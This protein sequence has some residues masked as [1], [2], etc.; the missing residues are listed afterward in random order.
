VWCGECYILKPIIE[1]HIRTLGDEPGQNEKDPRDA[2]RIEKAWGR[3]KPKKGDC[4]NARNS[5]YLKVPF[6]CDLCI[7]PKLKKTDPLPRD[8]QDDPLLACVRCMTLD[9]FWSRAWDTVHGNREKLADK[10]ALSQLVGLQGP[11]IHDGPYPDYNHY[12][13]EVA[14]DMLLMSR[15]AGRNS[16]IHLQ[17]DTIRK[18]QLV[19][20]N[21]ARSS[22][23]STKTVMA[24]DD[25]KGRYLCFS[26][27]PC[28][29]LWFYQFLE[30]CRYCMG[31]EWRPNQDMGIPLLLATLQGIK[32]K[33]QGSPTS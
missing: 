24:L 23:Q 30:G 15:R 12:G 9:S 16:K 19:Y 1:F 8:P 11:C 17:F 10:L 14:I 7:F 4:L 25:Q 13:Y 18:L 21:Q 6:E 3:K 28:A 22:P 20:G 32:D 33:I 26:T 29:S 31:Q 27:D 5:D 2:A